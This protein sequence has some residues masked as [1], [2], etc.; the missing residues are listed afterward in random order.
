M[1]VWQHILVSQHGKG[2]YRSAA[3]AAVVYLLW[4]Y[5]TDVVFILGTGYLYIRVL[6]L[7]TGEVCCKRTRH[8]KRPGIAPTGWLAFWSPRPPWLRSVHPSQ[9]LLC[10]KTKQSVL[11]GEPCSER[12]IPSPSV[13][14][15]VNEILLC[16]HGSNALSEKTY[17][18]MY[19]VSRYWGTCGKK[20]FPPR[21]IKKSRYG[22]NI[23]GH[24]ATQM[25]API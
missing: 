14:C 15:L 19:V 23:N 21:W 25:W 2:F 18:Y 20:Y 22:E 13:L 10:W 9:L 11:R 24:L 12:E 3:A 4:S 5:S 7:C 16:F 8:S 6:R 1:S 17:L